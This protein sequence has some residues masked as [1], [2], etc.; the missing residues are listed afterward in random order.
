MPLIDL[1]GLSPNINVVRTGPRGGAPVVLLHPVG[2]DLTYWDPQFAC[3]CESYDVIAF[4]MP[5]HGRSGMLAEPP[6]FDALADVLGLVLDHA[7]V[8]PAHLVGLSVGGMIAQTFA[9]R[10]PELVRSLSLVGTLCTFPED[11][12]AA[13]RE[14]ARVAREQGMTAIAPLSIARWFPAKFRHRRPDI[15]DRAAKSLLLQ[16]PAF[17]A[18]MWDMI[19]ALDLEARLPSLTCPTLVVAGTEDINAPV[20]AARQIADAI[21]GAVL[22]EIDGVGHFPP[23]EAADEFNGRLLDFLGRQDTEAQGRGDITHA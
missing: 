9:L 5:G 3:L 19:A 13:L 18:S 23:L 6:T 10:R 8:H 21:A 11:V 2:L 1:A 17:H 16:D 15:M 7:N 14:R 12:R 22:H 20:T 4:D